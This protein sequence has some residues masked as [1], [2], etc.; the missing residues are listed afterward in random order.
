MKPESLVARNA[1]LKLLEPMNPGADITENGDIVIVKKGKIHRS[2]GGLR[3]Y[4][5]PMKTEED[6]ECLEFEFVFDGCNANL[7][8]RWVL[9]LKQMNGVCDVE[10]K[11]SD[12]GDILVIVTAEKIMGVP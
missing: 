12:E 5:Q 10:T 9:L 11:M 6:A 7:I 4:S 3:C 1:I 8:S 2:L